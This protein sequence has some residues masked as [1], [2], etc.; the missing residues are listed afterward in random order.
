MMLRIAF[1]AG[2]GTAL[3]TAGNADTLIAS[4]SENSGSLPPAYAWHYDVSFGADGTVS[5]RYCKGY[6]EVTPDCATR[7]DALPADQLAALT[8]ALAPIAADLAAKPVLEME[9]PPVGGGSTTGHIFAAGADLVLPPFPV[10]A[11]TARVTAALELLH[12][13]TPAGAIDDTKSH[14]VQPQ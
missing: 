4:Y 13:F 3:G 5:T 8:A 6:G 2:L 1:L 9:M 12:T 11:D 7:S 14:A 10:E